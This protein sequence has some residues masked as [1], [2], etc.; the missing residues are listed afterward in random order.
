MTK[1]LLSLMF[2]NP[3]GNTADFQSLKCIFTEPFAVTTYNFQQQSLL[4]ET[5]SLGRKP[6]QRLSSAISF[7]IRNTGAFSLVDADGRVLQELILNGKGSDGMS[8]RLYP[9]KVTR[10]WS[11][12]QQVGGCFSDKI[13]AIEAEL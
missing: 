6:R 12:I 9:Y 2:M 5:P 10:Y 8:D 13:P 3:V 7:Q 4:T 1:L 11:Q